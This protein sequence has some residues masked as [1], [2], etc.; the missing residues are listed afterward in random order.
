VRDEL[1]A[2]AETLT[3]VVEDTG[4]ELALRHDFAPKEREILLCGGMLEYLRR[5]AD[6]GAPPSVAGFRPLSGRDRG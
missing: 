2:G 3:V 1:A 5:A 6:G 4:E